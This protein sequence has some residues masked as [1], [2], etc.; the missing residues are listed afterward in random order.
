MSASAP[1]RQR[2]VERHRAGDVAGAEALYRE[3]LA[4]DPRDADAQQYLAVAIFQQGRAGEAL[5]AIARAAA[6]APGNADVPFNRGRMLAELGRHADAADAFRQALAIAPAH[7]AARYNLGG[8]LIA[9][10]DLDGAREAFEAVVAAAPNEVDAVTNLGIVLAAVGRVAEGAER[11]AHAVRLAP[12]H[13]EAW[14]HLGIA[15][16]RL[17]DRPAALA[18]YDGALAADPRHVEVLLNRGDVLDGLGRADEARASFE[19]A[20]AVDPKAAAPRRRLGGFLVRTAELEAARPVYAG[21]LADDPRDVEALYGAAVAAFDVV[22]PDEAAIPAARARYAAALDRIATTIAAMPASA[23]A[24][25]AAAFLPFYLPYQNG[26]DDATLQRRFGDAVCDALAGVAPAVLPRPPR[27]RPRVALVSAYVYVNSVSKL[28]TEGWIR[29]WD[30]E[31]F[32]LRV[33][34]LNRRRDAMTEEAEARAD[35]FVSGLPDEAAWRRALAEDAPDVIL[36]PEIGMDPVTARLAATRLAPLQLVTRG[37]PFTSGLRTVDAF[38]SSELM[39]PPDGER[40]YVERLVRLPNLSISYRPRRREPATLDRA[41]IGLPGARPAFLCCQSLYKYLPRHDR[42][43][44]EII[45]GVPD[46]ILVFIE[47]AEAPVTAVLRARLAR[48]FVEAGLDA[49]DRVRFVRRLSPDEFEALAGLCDVYL[50]S[51]EWS[52]ENTTFEC[53]ARDLP[54]VTHAGRYMRGRHTTA[55]MRMMGLGERVAT[56]EAAYV[57]EAIRLGR[58]A[59]ARAEARAELAA[60]KSRLFED[61]APVAALGDFLARAAKG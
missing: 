29:E 9:L 17:G 18:A 43:L 12:R 49:A 45:R 7:H 30:R 54:I 24:P 21:L 47:A 28:V 33:Y 20:V 34:A 5:E 1:A 23:A 42:M 52:G 26:D 60:R 39:E 46:S 51:L 11:L 6:L 35:A 13:V 16:E 4:A 55:M 27:D 3:A 14:R 25:G 40:H 44:V 48:A 2:A 53:L 58:D 50:D 38:L 61:R 15:R 10:R 57:A 22:Y 32:E 37:H 19:R 36:Y 41:S 31:R 8:E 56:T 59:A